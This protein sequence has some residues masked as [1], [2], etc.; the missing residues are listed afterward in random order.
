MAMEIVGWITTILL[1]LSFLPKKRLALHVAGLVASLCRLMY[2]ICLYY[3]S[4][5]NSIRPLLASWVV[6]CC[7]HLYSIYRF[8]NTV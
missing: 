3:F 4:A 7:M 8:R 1:W 5:D 2:M 6:M